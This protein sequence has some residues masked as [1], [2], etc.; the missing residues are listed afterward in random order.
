MGEI[1]LNLGCWDDIREGYINIDLYS[2]SSGVVKMD[3]ENLQYENDYADEILS[4]HV[5]EHFD[6]QQ[7]SRVLAEWYRVL[8]QGGRLHLETPDCLASFQAFIDAD[9]LKRLAICG[10]IF[11]QPWLPGQAHL[12]LWTE[13]HLKWQLSAVG[14]KNIARLVADS[15]YTKGP[16]PSSM[17]LNLEAFK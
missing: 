13:E 7:A 11:G 3:I 1:R 14:F 4:Y 16:H 10:H 2:E 6:F 12:F 9:K 5:I 15:N 17:S 8:K